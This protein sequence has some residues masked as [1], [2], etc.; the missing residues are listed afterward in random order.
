MSEIDEFKNLIERIESINKIIAVIDFLQKY[1]ESLEGNF[2][3]ASI[4]FNFFI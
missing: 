4:F 1:D 3:L 2:F